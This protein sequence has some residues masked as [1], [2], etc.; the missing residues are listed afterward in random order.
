MSFSWPA[1]SSDSLS[2]METG[3]AEL[4]IAFLQERGLDTIGVTLQEPDL[5]A[6]GAIRLLSFS[7]RAG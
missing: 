4:I 2:D 1:S 3:G 5:D 6:I 7:K